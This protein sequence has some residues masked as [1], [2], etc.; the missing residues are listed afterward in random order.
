MTTE[1]I[2]QTRIGGFGSSDAKMVAKI[3]KNGCLSDADRQR[4]AIML[5]LEE[6]PEFS[7]EATDYGNFI[8]ERVFEI[9][10]E[11]YPTAVSNPYYKSK[12]L[13]E[14]YGFDVFNHIDFEYEDEKRLIWIENKATKSTFDETYEAYKYQLYWH[15]FLLME[16]AEKTGKKPILMLSHY[17]TTDRN[18]FYQENFR[19]E[20]LPYN[21][22]HLN[23][24]ERG[25]EIISEAIKDFK[26]EKKEA[27]YADNLPAPLQEKIQNIAECFK[28][29][30]EA[31]KQVEDFKEKMLQLMENA[32][33]KSIQND[34]FKINLIGETVSTSFDTKLFQ[35]ENPELSKKYLR[36]S[37]RKS[38]VTIKT[39]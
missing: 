32:N 37:K 36:Q 3:A 9:I 5:G 4:L 7:T 24:F 6:K 39:Y 17:R 23:I 30:T 20:K 31:E 29:I 16:K 26:Y 28:R 34:F 21:N 2:K 11:K 35:S 38:Y 8:E 27:L 18:N 12:T 10:K 13:S 22:S 1:E 25:F 19:I 15:H 14:K 33:I